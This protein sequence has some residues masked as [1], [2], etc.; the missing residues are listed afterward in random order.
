MINGDKL[1]EIRE[2][3]NMT[4]KETA[5]KLNIA[6]TTLS[7][8]E[9]GTR[10]PRYD[11]LFSFS[12]LFDLGI[13]ELITYLYTPTVKEEFDIYIST[14]STSKEFIILD[15]KKLKI[16]P[17]SELLKI[18]EYAEMIYEKNLKK[19]NLNNKF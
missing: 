13:E 14:D 12:K 4:Q 17:I 2:S 19:G 16:L 5:Q 7:N 1:R 6:A 10:E 18:R 11:F 9:R 8:Y 15:A 3:R